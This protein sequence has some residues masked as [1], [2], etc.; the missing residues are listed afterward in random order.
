M[1][2]KNQP[3]RTVLRHTV[4]V[5][6]LKLRP[7][8][9]FSS[10]VVHQLVLGVNITQV[11]NTSVDALQACKYTEGPSFSAATTLGGSPCPSPMQNPLWVPDI[12]I[13]DSVSPHSPDTKICHQ[14]L[15][16]RNGMMM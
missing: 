3:K 6:L 14:R 1:R 2:A 12:S 10:K 9:G 16:Q 8:S 4:E 11:Q 5:S 7:W 13:P 15:V